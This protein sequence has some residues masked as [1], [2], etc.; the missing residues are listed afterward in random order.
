M[1]TAFISVV[2]PTHDRP[3][4]LGACLAALAAQTVRPERF[5]VIVVDDGGSV[6][7]GDVVDRHQ[8]SLRITLS[9]R[10]H[11]GPAAARNAG[12]ELAQGEVLAFTDD[13]C[14][15]DPD[16]LATIASAVER[17]PGCLVG[18][19]TENALSGNR[20]SEASQAVIAYLYAD[21]LR[22]TGGL[23]F[24]ASNNLAL[25]HEFF[26]KL[27]GFDP[28]FPEAAAEDRDLSARCRS[29]GGSLVYEPAAVV[30][31][32][33]PLGL[34]SLLRQYVAYGRGARRMAHAGPGIR[35][36]G[37]YAGMLLEPYRHHSLRRAVVVAPLIALT[38]IGTAIGYASGG[39]AVAARRY[40]PEDR[41]G[42]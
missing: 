42:A 34:S 38:Q 13:D 4:A 16:W 14:A 7:V 12:A 35:S 8:S 39:Q 36:P 6:E 17:S 26:D 21:G 9:R 15:P 32:A 10:P 11:A 19:R 3:A 20:C 29:A 5:E 27:G 41:A 25:E 1:R 22:R 28:S 31:H 2:V 23:P 30:R 40:R 33:H 24:V 18:G 37:F